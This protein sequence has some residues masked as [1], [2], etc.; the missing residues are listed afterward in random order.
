[1]NSALK[2]HQKLFLKMK[3][4]KKKTLSTLEKLLTPYYS[5][6]LQKKDIIDQNNCEK[7]NNSEEEDDDNGDDERDSS[8]IK[9]KLE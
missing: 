7:D 5:D 8:E 1:M 3:D 4:Q 2:L 6:K 9:E